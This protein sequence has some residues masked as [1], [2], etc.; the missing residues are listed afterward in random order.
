M[1][2]YS[3]NPPTTHHAQQSPPIK[4]MGM[5]MCFLFCVVEPYV[6]NTLLFVNTYE[7]EYRVPAH[8]NRPG[9]WVS[10]S[11]EP[12]F[13]AVGTGV[14]RQVREPSASYIFRSGARAWCEENRSIWYMSASS[15]KNIARLTSSET[16]RP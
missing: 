4:V 12:I 10:F 16:K 1:K 7:I 3:K 5:L 2:G 8:A 13:M 9:N 6:E 15:W 11:S 14:G